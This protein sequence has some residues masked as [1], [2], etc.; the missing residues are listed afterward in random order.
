MFLGRTS[1]Q[2]HFNEHRSFRHL[3]LYIR[4]NYITYKHIILSCLKTVIVIKSIIGWNVLLLL[5][6]C[7]W[8]VT[9]PWNFLNNHDVK[10]NMSVFNVVK[11]CP[12]LIMTVPRNSKIWVIMKNSKLCVDKLKVMC[13]YYGVNLHV[14]FKCE[15]HW[16]RS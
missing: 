11:L 4:N 6:R 10:I 3:K 16:R 15:I 12:W 13:D 5:L 14:T 9:T 2:L 8:S 1:R 7:V